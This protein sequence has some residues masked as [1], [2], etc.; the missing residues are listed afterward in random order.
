MGKEI[1]SLPNL[2][3]D[4]NSEIK[5]RFNLAEKAIKPMNSNSNAIINRQKQNKGDASANEKTL[6]SH[7]IL[8]TN[9][10]N[11]NSSVNKVRFIISNDDNKLNK[12]N[13]NNLNNSN[14]SVI[15]SND[16]TYKNVSA[17]SIAN[18]LNTSKNN[19]LFLDIIN[20]INVSQPIIGISNFGTKT[21]SID[22]NISSLSDANIINSL[23]K[24]CTGAKFANLKSE[25]KIAN[26]TNNTKRYIS[27]TTNISN[28]N[29]CDTSD[30]PNNINSNLKGTNVI[31]NN[32]IFNPSGNPEG[33]VSKNLGKN[34]NYNN[35]FNDVNQKLFLSQSYSNANNP[36]R[37]HLNAHYTNSFNQSKNVNNTNYSFN[38]DNKVPEKVGSGKTN[39]ISIYSASS[40]PPST[41]NLNFI[42]F[43]KNKNM[44]WNNENSKNNSSNIKASYSDIFFR[45]C[46]NLLDEGNFLLNENTSISGA[47]GTNNNSIK[48][49]NNKNNNCLEYFNFQTDNNNTNAFKKNIS[50]DSMN[51]DSHIKL[52]YFGS[53]IEEGKIK[54]N[55]NNNNQNLLITHNENQTLLKRKNNREIDFLN[56]S[57]LDSVDDFSDIESFNYIHNNN[58]SLNDLSINNNQYNI[59]NKFNLKNKNNISFGLVPMAKNVK[60]IRNHPNS[61]KH[62]NPLSGMNRNIA[63]NSS[64]ENKNFVNALLGSNN[65]SN[66]SNTSINNNLNANAIDSITSFYKANYNKNCSLGYKSF[67]FNNRA[68]NTTTKTNTNNNSYNFFRANSSNMVLGGSNV[69]KSNISKVFSEYGKQNRSIPENNSITSPNA[70]NSI[71]INDTN[72]K[73]TPTID[74]DDFLGFENNNNNNNSHKTYLNTSNHNHSIINENT[75]FNSIVSKKNFTIIENFKKL[76]KNNDN[77]KIKFN[78]FNINPLQELS[79]TLNKLPNATNSANVNNK[80]KAEHQIINP[81]S[82]SYNIH[83]NSNASVNYDSSNNNNSIEKAKLKLI[84]IDCSFNE[85]KKQ[86]YNIDTNNNLQDKYSANS[87]STDFVFSDK[88][89][90]NNGIKSLEDYSINNGNNNSSN[91][92]NIA[93][94]KSAASNMSFNKASFNN[95]GNINNKHHNASAKSSATNQDECYSEYY[96]NNFCKHENCFDKNNNSNNQSNYLNNKNIKIPNSNKPVNNIVHTRGY[97]TNEFCNDQNPNI[98]DINNLVNNL[99]QNTNNS[100]CLN[101]NV[102]NFYN[103]IKINI[104]HNEKPDITL[105]DD[106]HLSQKKNKAQNMKSS[107]ASIFETFSTNIKNNKGICNNLAASAINNSINNLNSLNANKN[108]SAAIGKVIRHKN[109]NNS[110]NSLNPSQNFTIQT[111]LNTVKSFNFP[112]NN[113]INSNIPANFNNKNNCSI[114][115]QLFP[116]TGL[117]ATNINQLEEISEEN[118]VNANSVNNCNQ[119]SE[120]VTFMSRNDNNPNAHINNSSNCNEHRENLSN[121]PAKNEFLNINCTDNIINKNIGNNKVLAVNCNKINSLTNVSNNNS[122]NYSYNANTANCNNT[123]SSKNYKEDYLN[124]FNLNFDFEHENCPQE[125]PKNNAFSIYMNNPK[126]EDE[127]LGFSNFFN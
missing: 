63:N 117:E 16:N 50:I 124:P 109:F 29:N 98:N 27:S 64:T 112:I 83:K 3:E 93:K 68:N 23:N 13:E 87:Q 32:K 92:L 57:E 100:S 42:Q 38:F 31:F 106:E 9:S 107:T 95:I 62:T 49:N 33:F 11:N 55:I 118:I 120:N 19:L 5:Q 80:N 108:K 74:I 47:S 85:K 53:R 114:N 110:V 82:N 70:N 30:C 72:N 113:N 2:S 21:N 51:N 91:S 1:H 52:D 14:G 24:N 99:P 20:K 22:N 126:E 101:H 86:N 81:V 26:N 96:E 58:T 115:P 84:N 4:L 69:S 15:L 7:I 43:E 25:S 8:N 54:A 125:I 75:E 35:H 102:N 79:D 45:S 18:S 88:T 89:L 123:Q 48:N 78:A 28:K 119:S 97:N 10:N 127:F 61:T 60:I 6:S 39:N 104:Y 17:N 46:N 37:N 111:N 105:N 56:S 12:N 66:N 121:I 94:Q 41:G 76:S 90:I 44:S 34:C 73:N 122:L 77:G 36:I 59:N 103:D 65:S 67:N 71:N 116:A 40:K